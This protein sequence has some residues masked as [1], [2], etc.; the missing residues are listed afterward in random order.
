[1]LLTFTGIL[2]TLFW[3]YKVLICIVATVFS[4]TIIIA[5]FAIFSFIYVFVKIL[6]KLNKSEKPLSFISFLSIFWV[7]NDRRNEKRETFSITLRSS[8]IFV[9]SKC[10]EKACCRIHY[11]LLILSKIVFIKEFLV[12]LCQ[13]LAP[14]TIKLLEPI[15]VAC[16]WLVTNWNYIYLFYIF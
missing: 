7:M 3:I 5:S 8:I 9:S 12:L 6:N 15:E 11:K 10:Y 4:N 16:L 1:M 13:E 2:L 14:L